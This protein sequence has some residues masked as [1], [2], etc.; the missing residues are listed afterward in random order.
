V[1][2]SSLFVLGD[3]LSDVGNVAALADYA[4]NQP[5]DP[6]TVG[7]CNPT[8]VLVLK[9]GC[10]DLFY[11]ES[12]VTDGPVAVE[13]LA[14]DLGLPP[15]RASLHVI[16]NQPRLGTVYA[17]G[18]A[19]ARGTRDAD[20]ARQVDWLLIDRAPLP[21]DALYVVMIGGNDAID[22]MQVDAANPSAAVKP[23][24]AVVKNAANAIGTQVERLLDFGARRIVVANVP[25]L[26]TLPRTRVMAR[27]SA[28]EAA[29][30]AAASAIS[31]AFN[32]A[33]AAKLDAVE[34]KARWAPPTPLIVRFDL[35]A[36]LAVG[37][38]AIAA[39]GGNGVDACFES[40]AYRDAPQAPRVFHPDCAPETADGPPRFSRFAFWDDIHPT[41][42]LHA[43][44]GDAL[45]ALL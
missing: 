41:G 10:D 25:D 12:R 3:S 29:A 27:A 7:L 5:I 28:D 44:L 30:L 17:V 32:D 11:L 14:A 9:R 20:L 40:H 38:D 6:P 24:T 2:P 22:G 39:N 16:P 45:H 34:A 15:L 35:N 18:G 42:A 37:S 43:A 26:A 33:L 36:A 19:K 4:L 1:P 23:S 13:R 8:E 31:V 21:Q